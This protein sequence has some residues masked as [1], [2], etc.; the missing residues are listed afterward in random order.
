MTDS[1]QL[2]P[3]N[4]ADPMAAAEA[5]GRIGWIKPATLFERYLVEQAAGTRSCWVAHLGAVFAGYVAVNWKPT[6]PFFAA[7]QIPE[8]QDLNVLP[9]FRCKGLGTT[10]LAQAETE[11]SARSDIAGLSVGLHPGYNDAQKLYWKRGYIPDG[12][13]V[14]YQDR[15]VREGELVRLDDDFLLHLLRRVRP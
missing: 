14:T 13:G 1:F 3:M 15:E 4:S 11:I 5:F 10:L 9:P 12:Q 2:R 6:Y 8:I 7:R